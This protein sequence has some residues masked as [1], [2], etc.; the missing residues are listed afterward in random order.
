[1]QH[2]ISLNVLGYQEEGEWVALA[3]EM[4]LRGYGETFDE[5]LEDLADVVGMQ[6]SFSR[7]K[8]QPCLIWKAAD[9]VWFERFAETRRDY[10]EALV[11]ETELSEPEYSIAGLPIPPAHVIEAMR[12]SFVP[13]EV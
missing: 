13:T 4:D 3:L 2:Q 10:L 8:G 12:R 5:A 6:I 7:F 1:M 9:P 11:G